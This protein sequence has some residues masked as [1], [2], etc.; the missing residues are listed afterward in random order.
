MHAIK[1]QTLLSS[2]NFPI[3]L[4][5]IYSPVIGFSKRWRLC[6]NNAYLY[7]GS[8]EVTDTLE[9]LQSTALETPH[10]TFLPSRKGF[11]ER[12]VP[13]VGVWLCAKHDLLRQRC[14]RDR[15]ANV[16]VINGFHP[17]T[18]ACPQTAALARVAP[19]QTFARRKK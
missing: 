11:C 12:S 8:I 15:L 7:F 18:A 10:L 4:S 19:K 13:L 6:N 14:R 17:Q 1:C 3:S 5:L 2:T 16:S 9:P